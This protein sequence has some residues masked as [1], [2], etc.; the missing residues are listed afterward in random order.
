MIAIHLG[1]SIEL[2]PVAEAHRTG[3]AYTQK[4][5]VGVADRNPAE[6]RLGVTAREAGDAE[7]P[8]ERMRKSLAEATWRKD[9]RGRFSVT[10]CR[11]VIAYGVA[12]SPICKRVIS[13]LTCGDKALPG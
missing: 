13:L 11:G 4:C 1:K 2:Y 9:C 5:L 3:R 6:G 10:T 7:P 8:V 12:V